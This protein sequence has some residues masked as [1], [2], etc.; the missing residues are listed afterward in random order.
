ML[1]RSGGRRLAAETDVFGA[2]SIEAPASALME[3]ARSDY[4]RALLEDEPVSLMRE[5]DQ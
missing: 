2:V 4:V 1:Q 3:L 5:S